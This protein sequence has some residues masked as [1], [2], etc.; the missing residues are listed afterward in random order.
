MDAVEY[1]NRNGKVFANGVRWDQETKDTFIPSKP[2]KIYI[3]EDCNT[4]FQKREYLECPYCGS[5]KVK[6]AS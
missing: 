5:D 6:R 2:K 1:M 4:T 3:C